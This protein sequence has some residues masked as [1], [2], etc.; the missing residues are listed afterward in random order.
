MCSVIFGFGNNTYWN[1]QLQKKMWKAIEETEPINNNEQEYET[2]QDETYQEVDSY[3]DKDIT[4]TFITYDT[5]GTQEIVNKIRNE[6]PVYRIIIEDKREEK[7]NSTTNEV[8][9]G[10]I[11]GLVAFNTIFIIFKKL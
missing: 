9:I 2:T 10:V 7:S 11:L 1:W 4:Q 3:D 6:V 8:L 5:D